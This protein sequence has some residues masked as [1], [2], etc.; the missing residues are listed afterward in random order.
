MSTRK[1]KAVRSASPTHKKRKLSKSP[2]PKKS[3]NSDDEVRK[4]RVNK[5][6]IISLNE[7][8]TSKIV[9]IYG[10]GNNG[11]GQLAVDPEKVDKKTEASL[12]GEL[13]EVNCLDVVCGDF[14]NIVVES[15]NV[16]KHRKVYNWGTMQYVRDKK[17]KTELKEDS[18][19]FKPEPLEILNKVFIAQASAGESHAAVLSSDGHVYTWG[20]Y[21]DEKATDIAFKPNTKEFQSEP[22]LIDSSLFNDS[23]VVH[24]ASSGNRT[25]ELTQ[26]GEIYEWGYQK[27]RTSS[28][29]SSRSFNPSIVPIQ[30]KVRAIF[31][32][33]RG[34]IVC[35]R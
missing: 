2:P 18:M 4:T 17:S 33:C 34:Y 35:Y 25:L 23:I 32:W 5:T 14:F 26:N 30:E 3:E 1:R 28:R 24:I 16:T 9:N 8:K 27:N 22:E 10:F 20:I 15:S 7:G 21:K 31:L 6:T 12:I 19:S 11:F 13:E 29:Y